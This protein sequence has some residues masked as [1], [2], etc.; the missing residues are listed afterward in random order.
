MFY[1]V[2]SIILNTLNTNLNLAPTQFFGLM[3]GKIILP[4][5]L[6]EGATCARPTFMP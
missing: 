3:G 1:G 5:F 4:E 2:I 6:F